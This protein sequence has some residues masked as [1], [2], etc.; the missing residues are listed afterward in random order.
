[1]H[2][3]IFNNYMPMSQ[4]GQVDQP[5]N[6]RPMTM[7]SGYSLTIHFFTL[8]LTPKGQISMSRPKK[9]SSC[10]IVNAIFT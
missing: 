5:K 4:M 2:M 7:K 10:M 3:S 9:T 8:Y 6:A 1:M